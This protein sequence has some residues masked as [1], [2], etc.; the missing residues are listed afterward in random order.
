M[1]HGGLSVSSKSVTLGPILTN[2]ATRV[3]E[4]TLQ[5]TPIRLIG[6][7]PIDAQ[8][9]QLQSLHRLIDTDA[10]SSYFC[11]MLVATSPPNPQDEPP[12]LSSLL[13]NYSDIFQQPQGL[14]PARPQDHS[15]HLSSGSGPV[16]VRPYRYPYFQKQVME[17][18]VAEM[19]ASGIIRPSTSPFS[20]P[21]LLVRKKDG[22]WHF[23]VDYRA[24]NAITM[25]DRFPIP[26]ADELFDEL[27]GSQ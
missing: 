4:F 2:Y 14:P 5:E 17:Q 9:V 24:L 23:C 11:L 27:H 6:D 3:M 21:V 12:D 7:S 8:P 22:S 15:I 26:N 13:N 20:S 19:L 25:R 16:N 18:L 1:P 10:V